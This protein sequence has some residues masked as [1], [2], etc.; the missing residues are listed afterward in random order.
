MLVRVERL[1][2]GQRRQ[3]A[4]AIVGVGAVALVG[5]LDVGEEE[6]LVGDDRAA[7]GELG[8]ATARGRGAQADG[9][10]LAGGVGHLRGDRALPDQLVDPGLAGLTSRATSSGER[11]RSPAGRMA[12]WASC[13][14]FTFLA[15]WR[16]ASG[17][18]CSP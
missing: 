11:K 12:S 4:L 8:V 1:A 18:Y 17:R 9:D 16:G 13:A 7:R 2:L 14:F 10:R 3:P 15:Y 5:V 6:A